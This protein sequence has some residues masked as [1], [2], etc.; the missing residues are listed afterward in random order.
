MYADDTTLSCCLGDTKGE[1]KEFR[2]NPKLQHVQD[3]LKVTT[4]T[5]S[6]KKTKYM[7]FH[8]HN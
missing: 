3:W 6:V 5:L 1:N 8:E 7:M 2:I 4:L